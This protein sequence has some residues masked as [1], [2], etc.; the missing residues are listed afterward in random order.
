MITYICDTDLEIVVGNGYSHRDSKLVVTK[1]F[2]KG[3]QLQSGQVQ[4]LSNAVASTG[5]SAYASSKIV[6]GGLLEY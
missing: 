4:A 5:G 6:L 1:G 2:T 3:I